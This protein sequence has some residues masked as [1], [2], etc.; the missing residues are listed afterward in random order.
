[1]VK[2]IFTGLA[3]L[4]ENVVLNFRPLYLTVLN[5]SVRLERNVLLK[6]PMKNLKLGKDV[7]V[8][9]N[10]VLHLGGRNW[11]DNRGRIEIGEQSIIS[12][13]CVLWGAGNGGIRIGRRFD[14]GPFVGIYACRSDYRLKGRHIFAPVEIG[15]EVTVF[16]HSVIGPGVRI[17]SRAVIAAGSVVLADVPAGVMVGGQ[18]A[19]FLKEV[20]SI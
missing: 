3:G 2:T 18:P 8:Q 7:V 12:P 9:A 6:G 15:D 20:V 5:P 4:L 10:T 11:C 13:N 19:R 16:S 17:G 1:M 14:C